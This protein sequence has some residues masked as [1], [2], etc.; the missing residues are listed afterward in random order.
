MTFGGPQSQNGPKWNPRGAL[1]GPLGS[2]LDV[3]GRFFAPSRRDLG[4]KSVQSVNSLN[5]AVS[6]GKTTYFVGLAAHVGGK[7]A[8][9]C[10]KMKQNETKVQK[11]H[12]VTSEAAKKRQTSGQDGPKW[13]TK[14]NKN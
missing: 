7:M 11:M 3:F 9:K 12:P 14:G 1:W 6:C 8:P 5:P 13:T 2:F 10:V 4:Q